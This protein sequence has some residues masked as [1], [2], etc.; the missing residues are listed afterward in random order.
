[1]EIM[2]VY[3]QLKELL[4]NK[5]LLLKHSQNKVINK[6]SVLILSIIKYLF[7]ENF[8]ILIYLN[9]IKYIKQLILYIWSFKFFKEDN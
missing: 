1:M 4:I 7:L 8:N 5:G 3:I 2:L 6:T 9:Y